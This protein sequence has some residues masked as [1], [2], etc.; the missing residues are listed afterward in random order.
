M[1]K[2]LILG[3][4]GYGKTVADV[5]AQLGVYEKIRFL[6]DGRTGPDILGECDRYAE[7]LEEDTEVYPAFGNNAFRKLWLERLKAADVPVPTLVHPRAYV[8]PRATVGEGSVVLPMAVVNTGVAVGEGVAV[9]S[10][11]AM[12][13]ADSSGRIPQPVNTAVH[14]KATRSIYP[15]AF[16]ISVPPSLELFS[17]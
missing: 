15:K 14:S 4:G 8:S 11:V 2:L 13:G 1:K 16:F 7:F 6:D 5:A 10:A 17:L 3:A 12:G 9:G